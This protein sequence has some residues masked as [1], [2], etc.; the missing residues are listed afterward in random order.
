MLQAR[1]KKTTST[2]TLVGAAIAV[3]AG[4]GGGVQAGPAPAPTWSC[5]PDNSGEPCTPEKA[6]AQAEEA[7]AYEEAMHAYRE[8]TK[9]RNRLGMGGGTP[10]PT[11]VM[12]RYAT[13]NY[14]N[15][16]EAFLASGHAAGRRADSPMQIVR[17][18]R[19]GFSGQSLELLACEDGRGVDILDT[20]GRKVGTGQLGAVLLT[21]AKVEGQ[22]VVSDGQSIG[23]ERCE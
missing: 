23:A 4:C 11:A 10:T 3:L 13:G 15:D 12:S 6:A 22:W 20:Q 8:F 18:E 17:L 14:L 5:T 1:W 19:V 21:V 16:V 2:L 9:E 7:A